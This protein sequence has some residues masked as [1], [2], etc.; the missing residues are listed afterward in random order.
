[1]QHTQAKYDSLDGNLVSWFAS[2]LRCQPMPCLAAKAVACQPFR[3]TPVGRAPMRLFHPAARWSRRLDLGDTL[4]GK[5]RSILL[6]GD[7]LMVR[8]S[9]GISSCGKQGKATLAHVIRRDCKWR[10]ER[11][12]RRAASSYLVLGHGGFFSNKSLWSRCCAY[13]MRRRLHR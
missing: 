8:N 13:V 6:G 3:S 1:M 7:P 11:L 10:C 12:L 9:I 5:S 2:L 4:Y